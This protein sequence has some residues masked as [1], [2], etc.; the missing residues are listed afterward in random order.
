MTDKLFIYYYVYTSYIKMG[1][2][3]LAACFVMAKVILI[4]AILLGEVETLVVSVF[5]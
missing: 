5:S 1:D 4:L 3:I 2:E